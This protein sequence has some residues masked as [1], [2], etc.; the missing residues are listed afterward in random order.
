MPV[1]RHH[2]NALSITRSRE[3]QNRHHE[4]DGENHAKT[5]ETIR[6]HSEMVAPGWAGA[7]APACAD[8]ALR[9]GTAANSE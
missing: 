1:Q 6:R 8:L 9:V 7:A 4:N 2:M 3:P 5:S